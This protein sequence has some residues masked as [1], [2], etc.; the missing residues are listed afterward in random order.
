MCHVT[1]EDIIFYLILGGHPIH[2]TKMCAWII[3]LG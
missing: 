2:D 1:F 3:N